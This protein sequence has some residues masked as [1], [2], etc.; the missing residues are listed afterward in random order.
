MTRKDYVMIAKVIKK[1]RDESAMAKG[2]FSEMIYS[3]SKC[4]GDEN[5]SFKSDV[6]EKACGLETE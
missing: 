2:E 4:F 3:F 6:F 1:H 5:T